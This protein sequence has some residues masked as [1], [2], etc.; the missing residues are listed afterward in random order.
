MRAGNYPLQYDDL[1]AAARAYQKALQLNPKNADALNNMGLVLMEQEKFE[2]ARSY[3]AKAIEVRPDHKESH[4]NLGII[5]YNQHKLAE[6]VA[7][8]HEALRI[9]PDYFEPHVT[10]GLARLEV[11]KFKE[12]NGHFRH[13]IRLSPNDPFMHYYLGLTFDQLGDRTHAAVQYGRALEFKPDHLESLLGLASIR[14]TSQDSALRD[15]EEAV[16]LATKACSLTQYQDPMAMT[17]LSEA[18]A[19]AGRFADAMSTAQRALQIAREAGNEDLANG[20][21]QRLE[22]YRQR[23]SARQVDPR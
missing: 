21:G 23:K 10:L 14:A 13:A 9:D 22:L 7:H 19:E 2:E 17:T 12:A 6:A 20:I 8:W 3:I 16:Q 15:G 4:Q 1:P 5:L 11:G 18:Y